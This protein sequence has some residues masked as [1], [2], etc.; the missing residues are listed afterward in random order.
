[1]NLVSIIIPMYNEELS[2]DK[3]IEV[4]KS[5][6][7]QNFDVLFIDDGS[8]DRT[9]EKLESILHLTVNFNYKL[10]KQLNQ[11]AAGARK[12]GIDHAVTKYIMT[13]DC[14]DSLSNDLVDE[15]YRIYSKYTDVDIILPDMHIENIYR[16]WSKFAFYT[17]DIK[18]NY[19]DCVNYS[20]DGW[21]VHGFMTI[22]KSI[23]SKSYADYAQ[24]NFYNENYINNDEVITRLNFFNSKNII[25]S[26]AIYYYCYNKLSTTKKI[27]SNKY[28]IINNA[29]IINDHYSSNC[30]IE[31]S[32]N[33]ELIAV[34]W[35]VMIYMYKNR[36][37][38]EN[39]DEW[40]KILNYSVRKIDYINIFSRLTIKKRTQLTI[41]KLMNLF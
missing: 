12:T 15:V 10:V 30:E 29:I 21:R 27:N 20:L 25:R 37:E 8:Q 9:V 3:C 33:N 22:K 36:E 41:L 7:N 39:I 6:T 11:G 13:F 14:D 28:L 17:A 1:M 24:Y 23:I 18:L 16:E 40:E 4:L 35:G 2:I 5:Q 38:L 31:V 32:A 34:I 19:I 26:K